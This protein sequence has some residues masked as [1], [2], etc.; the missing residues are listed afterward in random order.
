MTDL[1][2]ATCDLEQLSNVI[3]N[4]ERKQFS[5]LQP[6]DKV[7]CVKVTTREAL[8]LVRPLDL[9]EKFQL[10]FYQSQLVT[11]HKPK[12]RKLKIYLTPTRGFIAD[13]YS[14]AFIR[15]KEITKYSKYLQVYG[16]TLEECIFKAEKTLNMTNIK[17]KLIWT[18]ANI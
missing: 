11:P 8:G 3:N 2:F 13:K 18:E 14:S 16:T 10:P 15:V 1:E 4:P 7:Y 12:S 5:E 6:G 9:Y 17:D